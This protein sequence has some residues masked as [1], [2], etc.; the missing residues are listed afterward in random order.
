MEQEEILQRVLR[1]VAE[2]FPNE[3]V[4]L[5]PTTRISET[6][7]IDSLS[8]LE[9]VMFLED[10]FGLELERADLRSVD[11]PESITRLILDK[12]KDAAPSA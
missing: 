2:Q 11:T 9:V 3:A 1:F 5:T 7:L 12:R 10:E 8:V 6:A 4:E